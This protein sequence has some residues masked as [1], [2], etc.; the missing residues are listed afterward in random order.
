[1]IST[2]LPLP[3][4]GQI[5]IE[6]GDRIG[7]IAQ[8][9]GMNGELAGVR[10]EAVLRD[11]E[12]ASAEPGVDEL[13][14]QLQMIAQRRRRI[15][16]ARLIVAADRLE[17]LAG[18]VGL[19]GGAL[20]EIEQARLIGGGADGAVENLALAAAV[21]GAG[22]LQAQ[23]EIVERRDR[24]NA[25]RAPVKASGAA[26][27]ELARWNDAAA[28]TCRSALPIQPS[29]SVSVGAG[30]LPDVHRAEVRLARIRIADALHDAQ[31]VVLEQAVQAGHRRVQADAG[32]RRAGSW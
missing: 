23:L 11:V 25:R 13:G 8:E 26:S 27:L 21:G 6:G 14:G 32:R 1:M 12:Q 10:V 31:G 15:R 4:R 5:A 29:V 7:D 3:R 17:P 20:D 19:H 2:R 22:G 30:G 9:V 16:H 24:G 28:G 18:G